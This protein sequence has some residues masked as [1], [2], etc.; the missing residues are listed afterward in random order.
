MAGLSPTEYASSAQIPPAAN[1]SLEFEIRH[2]KYQDLLAV[3]RILAAAFWDEDAVGRFMHPE[4][5]KFPKD[6]ERWWTRKLR[7]TFV[8]WQHEMLIAVDPTGRVVGFADW[9]R[10]G[11]GAEKSMGHGWRW[12]FRKLSPFKPLVLY[13]AVACS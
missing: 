2:V 12:T 8:L 3:A 9:S 4:R 13:S 5:E 7:Y 1:A 10:M 6:V 11:P